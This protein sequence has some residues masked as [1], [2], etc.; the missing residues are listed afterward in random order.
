MTSSENI[1]FEFKI[2]TKLL[3]KWK[4][5][6]YQTDVEISI[7]FL[8]IRPLLKYNAIYAE[9]Q[10]INKK[11]IKKSVIPFN[12]DLSSNGKMLRFKY[13]ISSKV[14]IFKITYFDPHFLKLVE[15]KTDSKFEL[16]RNE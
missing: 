10:I 12:A 4:L 8:E 9:S 15:I 11:A 16:I 7:Q 5:Q 14:E 13:P 2:N 1:T 6:C 3:G